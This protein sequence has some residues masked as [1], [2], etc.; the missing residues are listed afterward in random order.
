[1]LFMSIYCMCISWHGRAHNETKAVWHVK[2]TSLLSVVDESLKC[3]Q[4][5]KVF[6]HLIVF[7]HI[8]APLT[9]PSSIR[10]FT[11]DRRRAH[12]ARVVRSLSSWEEYYSSSVLRGHEPAGQVKH[13]YPHRF[14]PT[15]CSASLSFISTLQ[16]FNKINTGCFMKY[17]SV[18]YK[19]CYI[20]SI[21]KDVSM[22]AESGPFAINMLWFICTFMLH[23]LRTHSPCLL[24][25]SS[26]E[27]VNSFKL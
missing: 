5:Q 1:M 18:M 19:M 15:L 22:W 24:F 6:K 17:F 13:L 12:R 10:F 8:L 3:T 11:G 20:E 4:A 25:Q 2:T 14:S 26:V 21:S 16:D 27:S 7:G 23:Y 9:F